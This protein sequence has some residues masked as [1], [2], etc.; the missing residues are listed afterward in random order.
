LSRVLS[1][2]AAKVHSPGRE[3]L[4]ALV[5]IIEAP[6]GNAAKHFASVILQLP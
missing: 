3:P 6:M 5:K 1:R 2:N 4:E